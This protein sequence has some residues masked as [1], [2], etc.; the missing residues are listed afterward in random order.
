MIVTIIRYLY[1]ILFFVTPFL[2]AS[3]TSELF[4]FNKMMFVYLMTVIILSFWILLQAVQ[5]AWIFKLH[6]LGI[7]LLLF[8]SS[9]VISTVLSIDVHTSIFGYYGRFNGGLLSIIAYFILFFVFVQISDKKHLISS[10]KATFIS[11][12]LVVLWGIP[13]KF[14]YDLTCQIFTGQLTNSCWTDQFRPAERMFSTLGQ[15]NWLGAYLAIQF[16]IGLWFLAR[17]TVYVNRSTLLLVLAEM[18]IFAGLLFTRSRS[19]ILAAAV[20][21]VVF[22]VL[23]LYARRKNLSYDIKWVGMFVILLIVSLFVIKT[24]YAPID[25]FLSFGRPAV[26]QEA[27]PGV[28]GDGSPEQPVPSSVT[29]SFDIRKIV[30]D[31]AVALGKQNPLFGTGVETYAYAYYLTRPVEHNYTSEWDFLYNKAHNEFLNYFA[32]TGFIGLGSYVAMIVAVY[33]LMGV[34]FI[35]KKRSPDM[36]LLI[37]SL[38]AAY[39]TIHI[40]NFFGFSISVIQV[41]F[42][43]IPAFTLII[44]QKDLIVKERQ[45]PEEGIVKKTVTAISVMVL[46]IGVIYVG[47]YYLADVSY[48]RAEAISRSGDYNMAYEEFQKALQLRYEHVYQDKFSVTLANLSFLASY[49]D[50][51]ELAKELRELS[52]QY[53]MASIQASPKNVIYHKTFAKNKYVHF[54]VTLDKKYLEEAVDQ[55]Q[56]AQKLAPTDPKLPYT[57]AL[58]YSLLYDEEKTEATKDEYKN[59]SLQE[60]NKSLD[61]K[62]NYTEGV[63]L[64]VQLLKKYGRQEEARAVLEDAV[65]KSPI[66]IP[67]YQ[68]ELEKLGVQSEN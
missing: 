61:L 27:Q 53:S 47:R 49:Q 1:Y 35:K 5:R 57:A 56:I 12:V 59:R 8:I 24:G 68:E 60:I 37:A 32:T 36:Q 4:E 62:S 42:Y 22:G 39:T 19:A 3:N 50:D 65:Q 28:Q 43:M 29:E 34:A 7:P 18:G 16:C 63:L 45:I 2:M 14:G 38:M 23:Y 51:K 44:L 26:Q 15:P 58:F 64:K 13:G 48:A 41:L 25:R 30:W 40:T 67:E 9:Q 21:A 17:R 66:T 52:D 10:L 31:G 20:G 46:I 33:V 11:A 54:Q 55:M 6:W